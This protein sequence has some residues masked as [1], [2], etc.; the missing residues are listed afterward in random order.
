MRPAEPDPRA[1]QEDPYPTVG[2]PAETTE[3]EIGSDAPA[4][5]AEDNTE[6]D[7]FV[8]QHFSPDSNPGS[9]LISEN[10]A[11]D[12]D[13]LPP[14]PTVSMSSL[15]EHVF[16]T[17][18]NRALGDFT[19]VDKLGSGGFGV[20]YRATDQRLDR[21]VAIKVIKADKI[22]DRHRRDSF[23]AEAKAVAQL[24]H[25]NIVPVHQAGEVASGQAFIVYQFIDGPTLRGYMRQHGAFAPKDAVKLLTKISDG[26]GYAH[27]CGI[28]HRDVKPEN[29]LIEHTTDEPHL[30]DFGCAARQ[31]YTQTVQGNVLSNV[32]IGTP[33]Y[34]SPEQA[35]GKSHLADARSDVWA[36][37]IVM[38]EMLTRRRTF[39]EEEKSAQTIMDLLNSIQKV[40]PRPLRERCE[41]IDRDLNAIWQKCLAIDPGDRYQTA[42]DLA[43]DLRR[44]TN[45]RPVHARPIGLAERTYRWSR[46]N[47]LVAGSLAATFLAI[48]I[49][50]ISTLLSYENVRRANSEKAQYAVELLV[51]AEPADVGAAVEQL[52]STSF[53]REAADVLRNEWNKLAVP[54]SLVAADPDRKQRAWRVALGRAALE[55]TMDELPNDGAAAG[56]VHDVV[57]QRIVSPEIGPRELEAA[58]QLL[59]ARSDKSSDIEWLIEALNS[60][61]ANHEADASTKLRAFCALGILGHMPTDGVATT[62]RLLYEL[63]SQDLESALGWASLAQRHMGSLRRELTNLQE[64][65][66][67][68]QSD[69]AVIDQLLIAISDQPEDLMRQIASSERPLA[70][71]LPTLKQRAIE[72][73]RSLGFDQ[74]VSVAAGQDSGIAPE[75]LAKLW[76]AQLYVAELDRDF[77]DI[78]RYLLR[79]DSPGDRTAETVFVCEAFESGLEREKL[80]D[81]S[82]RWTQSSDERLAAVLLAL[83]DYPP[84]ANVAA[85]KEYLHEVWLRDPH[86]TTHAASDWLMRRWVIETDPAELPSNYA[87]DS[88]DPR[89]W[90]SLHGKLFVRIPQPSE[91]FQVGTVEADLLEFDRELRNPSF[92]GFEVAHAQQ[93]VGDFEI[94]A[95][96][97]T[98]AEFEQFLDDRIEASHLNRVGNRIRENPT[99]SRAG[100]ADVLQMPADGLNWYD[101]VEYCIWLSERHG[102]ESCYGDLDDVSAAFEQLEQSRSVLGCDRTK[103]GYRLPTNGEWELACRAGSTTLWPFG[104]NSDY[105]VN[106]AACSIGGGKMLLTGSLRPNAMGLFDMLGNAAEMTDTPSEAPVG[107]QLRVDSPVR[108]AESTKISFDVRGGAYSESPVF[109]RTARRVA[110]A[111]YQDHFRTPENLG[112]GI[113]LVRTLAAETDGD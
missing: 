86:A 68:R 30:A 77:D 26:L 32:F 46:R 55:A 69:R 100:E 110:A 111:N 75:L 1:S 34:F 17:E 67:E 29:I 19:L 89:N 51:E 31:A 12:D 57:A 87:D 72:S 56:D 62:S 79:L 63:A 8:T 27:Q 106:Y 78:D 102:L 81:L 33:Q 47:P 35:A 58:S 88:G 24:R 105:I 41:G 107:G 84:P 101:A 7:Q 20:V 42:S 76:I 11:A 15:T 59:S 37:G 70:S 83:G 45:K 53:R 10:E 14:L 95:E 112:L 96:E 61:A 6:I 38:D 64:T 4:N 22:G 104:R 92:N 54:N 65:L 36:L 13:N 109:V 39:R 85:T 50:W 71:I 80:L 48:I 94:A 16:Q 2:E 23:Q 3:L 82:K 52:R 49:A 108:E 74:F 113:R 5:P 93:I 90:R 44:W 60:V 25:P 66:G 103:S 21:D 9:V 28:V 18:D 43:A 98:V 40:R 99:K 91:P 97:V 73:G